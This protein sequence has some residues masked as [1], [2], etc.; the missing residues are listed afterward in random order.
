MNSITANAE[1][2]IQSKD[3]NIYV[4]NRFAYILICGERRFLGVAGNI[5]PLELIIH[6]RFILCD[7]QIDLLDISYFQRLQNIVNQRKR[8]V[9]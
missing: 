2:R 8:V 6:I 1:D 7:Y 5:L 4:A 9:S 3:V